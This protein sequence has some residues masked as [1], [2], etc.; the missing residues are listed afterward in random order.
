MEG[1]WKLAGSKGS[2]V[3]RANRVKRQGRKNGSTHADGRQD[4]EVNGK[5]RPGEKRVEKRREKGAAK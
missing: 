3:E 4:D 5:D 2:D 1:Q